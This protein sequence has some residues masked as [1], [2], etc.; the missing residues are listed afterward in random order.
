MSGARALGLVVGLSA[1]LCCRRVDPRQADW[2][3]ALVTVP[4]TGYPQAVY[5]RY[6]LRHQIIDSMRANLR[7]LVV[8]ESVYF[9][10]SGKY[11]TTTSCLVPPS[12][13]TAHWCASRDNLLES[14]TLTP[15]GWWTTIENLNTVIFCRIQ[16]GNDT[17]FGTPCAVPD[18]LA[19]PPPPGY[20]KAR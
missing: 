1:V 2:T 3:D 5:Q 7:A 8:A 11:T 19:S 18:C 17:T 10:D 12:P 15:H 16:V 20:P 13:G 14:I 4:E 9:A 6:K